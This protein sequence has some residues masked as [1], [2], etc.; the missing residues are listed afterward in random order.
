[1]ACDTTV[2]AVFVLLVGVTLATC[3]PLKIGA[4]GI[5]SMLTT[6]QQDKLHLF[7]PNFPR[8]AQEPQKLISIALFICILLPLMDVNAKSCRILKCNNLIFCW[9]V[10]I[11]IEHVEIQTACLELSGRALGIL[12]TNLTVQ[13]IADS[14]LTCKVALLPFS[15]CIT[16]K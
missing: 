8:C 15:H 7:S 14:F 3:Q 5:M 10:V 12:A 2:F 16:D 9:E 4:Q 11:E 13:V 6:S 1:M